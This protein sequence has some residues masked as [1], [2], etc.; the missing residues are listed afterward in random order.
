MGTRPCVHVQGNDPPV[1][2]GCSQ[3]YTYASR[4]V[5]DRAHIHEHAGG[6]T[7]ASVPDPLMLVDILWIIVHVLF[8]CKCL[9][10]CVNVP[11][12]GLGGMSCRG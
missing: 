8:I 5:T 12:L 9:T 6:L 3:T 2:G 1:G 4:S 10:C 11:I 7:T